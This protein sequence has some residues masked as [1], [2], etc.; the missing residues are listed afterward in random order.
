MS[1]FVFVPS[2]D[3]V[4]QGDVAKQMIAHAQRDD[5]EE[6]CGLIVV[7]DGG[8]WAVQCRNASRFP[9]NSFEIHKEDHLMAH[10][11]ADKV[12]GMYHSH[13]SGSA[14]PSISDLRFI[15]ADPGMLYFIIAD[16]V[17]YGY[18]VREAK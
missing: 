14:V 7:L 17:I 9:N 10:E 13:P 16:N 5:P 8:V 2:P 11:R 12:L 1:S 15:P 4:P 3:R 6:A 18:E